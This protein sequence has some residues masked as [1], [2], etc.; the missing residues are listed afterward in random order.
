MK[1]GSILSQCKTIHYYLPI[2]WLLQ[3]AT[4]FTEAPNLLLCI[5]GRKPSLDLFVHES[6]HG[7]LKDAIYLEVHRLFFLF[8]NFHLTYFEGA[9]VE[10][11]GAGKV[12]FR[13]PSYVQHI[14][15]YVE[16]KSPFFFHL[17]RR[18]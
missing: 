13:Y 16:E 6:Y 9:D 14:M 1:Y 8:D 5:K 4:V 2:P 12:E 11:R 7:P 18:N 15:G 10:K 17:E 3:W